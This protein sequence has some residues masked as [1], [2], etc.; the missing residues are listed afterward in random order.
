MHLRIAKVKR[1]GRVYE[2]A[3]LVESFRRPS[4][5]MPA[6]RTVA[7]LGHLDPQLINNLKLA[8]AAAREGK[9]VIIPSTVQPTASGITPRTPKPIQNLRYL[10]IAVL[11]HLWQ[12]WGLDHL[13]EDLMAK[14]AMVASPA[15]VTTALVLERCVEPRSTLQAEEWFPRTALPELLGGAVS[16]FNNSRLH[17]L[18]DTL[19]RLELPMQSR[20]TQCYQQHLGPFRHL[21]VDVTDTWFVGHGPT[22]S[23]FGQ[24][25]EGLLRRKINIVLL[26]NERGYPIRWQLAPGTDA[27]GTIVSQLLEEVGQMDWAKRIPIIADRALGKAVYLERFFALDL[28]FVIALTRSDFP[29]FAAR[30]PCQDLVELQ[31]AET[32]Q[33]DAKQI[34][35]EAARRVEHAGMQQVDESLCVLDLGVHTWRDISTPPDPMPIIADSE[36]DLPDEMP[37]IADSESD[38]A[39]LAMRTC[40]RIEGM[41]QSGLSP[42][43]IQAGKALRLSKSLSKKY[44]ALRNLSAD[45]QQQVL[46]GAAGPLSLGKL[47]T[48]AKIT[49]TDE[50]RSAFDHL[51]EEAGNRGASPARARVDPATLAPAESSPPL[52]VRIICGFNP[53]LFVHERLQSRKDLEDLDRFVDRIN[54]NLARPSSRR[55]TQ[56]AVLALESK[57]RKAC[58]L[59]LFT[60]RIESTGRSQVGQR[61]H[62]ELNQAQWERRRQRDGFFLLAAH[63]NLPHSAAELVRLYRS[64]DAI[65]KDFQVIKSHLKI[66]PVYHYTDCKVRAHVT[67]CMLALL[68]ERILDQQLKETTCNATRALEVLKWC[69]LNRFAASRGSAYT[70]TELDTDQRKILE[71]LHLEALGD[72]AYLIEHIHSR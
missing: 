7:N 64:K 56:S 41:L 9:A 13:L 23:R 67:V 30:I 31:P 34:A 62:L 10:D 15:D 55:T 2:Y 69:H 38:R 47:L 32:G 17:R 49:D 37:I 27:D 70:I 28:Y 35:A 66:R 45:I 11:L 72:D 20:L 12:Q 43:A 58:M 21:Y 8:L 46:A 24:T 53:E 65:E 29:T 36:S 3:Q 1:G 18:F 52:R 16:S 33:A 26:C 50:Q 25:K 19:D 57:L 40:R 4:D 44:R 54:G 14:T 61:V 6:Q 5:G 42:S 68:L 71:T 48:V 22:L 39:Q 51:L 63:P 60:I 59:E